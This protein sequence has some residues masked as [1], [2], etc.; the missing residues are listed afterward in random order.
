LVDR[1][2]VSDDFSMVLFFRNQTGI[3]LIENLDVFCD[4]NKYR[5][6]Y[7]QSEEWYAYYG[8]DGSTPFIHVS[9]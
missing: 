6:V 8:A 5:Y 2:P 9:I 1:P 4:D 7:Q 3:D